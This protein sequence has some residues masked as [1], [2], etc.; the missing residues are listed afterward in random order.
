M[1]CR[2]SLEMNTRGYEPSDQ[3]KRREPSSEINAILHF[4][5]DGKVMYPE[6]TA[7]TLETS[8]LLAKVPEEVAANEMLETVVL[9]LGRES[10]KG[11]CVKR[12]DYMRELGVRCTIK[13]GMWCS[14]VPVLGYRRESS[15]ERLHLAD[16]CWPPQH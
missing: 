14:T 15:S 7:P 13:C 4:P 16:G 11:I 3:K 9:L 10:N 6:K 12:C 1:A 5:E 2:K 8:A